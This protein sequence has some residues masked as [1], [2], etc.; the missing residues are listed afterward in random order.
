MNVAETGWRIILRPLRTVLA[1]SNV[2]N[3]LWPFAVNQIILVHNALSSASDTSHVSDESSFA[4]AF[5]ASLTKKQSPPSPY[6]NPRTWMVFTVP[7]AR[8]T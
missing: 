4:L 3:A 1:A 2:S 7:P 6:F 8:P 5:L